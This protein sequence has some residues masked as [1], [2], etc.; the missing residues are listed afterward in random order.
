[1]IIGVGIDMCCISRMER[2][3]RS[4][5]FLERVFRP[6]EISYAQRRGAGMASSLASAF[7][8]REAFCKAS[9]ASL[10]R[11]TIGG[12]FSLIRD[13]GVPRIV[14]SQE[15]ERELFGE[16]GGHIFVS[17]THEGDYA[18]AVVVLER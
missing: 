15:L 12:E 4:A 9:G 3:A 17:L 5:H 1:M 7:A 11:L 14:V 6:E 8:A 16:A 13:N 2:A 18:A 10:A